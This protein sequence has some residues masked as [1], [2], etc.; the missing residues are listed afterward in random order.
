MLKALFD[1]AVTN[2]L[3]S[4]PRRWRFSAIQCLA[5]WLQPAFFL[6]ARFQKPRPTFTGPRERALMH[7]VHKLIQLGADFET[8]LEVRPAHLLPEAG[9]VL[10][11]T[12]HIPANRLLLRWLCERGRQVSVIT[13]AASLDRIVGQYPLE[14][15]ELVFPD[16]HVFTHIRQRVKAGRIVYFT[17]ELPVSM[18]NSQPLQ[19]GEETIYVSDSALCFA[20]RA[21]LPLLFAATS[22]SPHGQVVVQ[23]AQPSTTKAQPAYEEFCQFLTRYVTQIHA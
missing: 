12:A 17:P 16:A 21:N 4:C 8:K 11:L 15:V 5:R 7:F 18:P 14:L 1:K 13:R 3:Q 20:E 9:G 6:K 22:V 19:L 23:L 10:L 2:L